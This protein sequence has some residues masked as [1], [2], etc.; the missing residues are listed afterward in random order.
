MLS[1]INSELPT[2]LERGTQTLILLSIHRIRFLTD[3]HRL[4]WPIEYMP[5]SYMQYICIALFSLLPYLN[6]LDNNKTFTELTTCLRAL[7][8]RS[9]LSKGMLRLVQSNAAK[10]VIAVPRE[11]DTLFKD[12]EEELRKSGDLCHLNSIYPSLAASVTDLDTL[13]DDVELRKFLEKW[14]NFNLKAGDK[15]EDDILEGPGA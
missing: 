10:K 7:A 13:L 2:H 4:Q 14:N 3:R 1:F 5:I 9:L 8:R 11:T 15:N 6:T 12:F